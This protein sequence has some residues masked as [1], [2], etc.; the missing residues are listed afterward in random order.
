[1]CSPAWSKRSRHLSSSFRSC[2]LAS[3]TSAGA[4]ASASG[5]RLPHQRRRMRRK[6]QR[7][8][9]MANPAGGVRESGRTAGTGR[10]RVRM[11]RQSMKPA[12]GG[13]RGPLPHL[14]R[15]I[16]SKTAMASATPGDLGGREEERLSGGAVTRKVLP[17]CDLLRGGNIDTLQGVICHFYFAVKFLSCSFENRIK[18]FLQQPA[19]LKLFYRIDFCCLFFK[20]RKRFIFVTCLILKL[21][22]TSTRKKETCEI[23]ERSL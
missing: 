1:M 16:G 13:V 18:I 2:S 21:F 12:G 11:R 7:S 5:T 22:L 17:N 15:I 10:A 20:E 14:A 3:L 19:G 23:M 8:C 6:N 9:R 4:H